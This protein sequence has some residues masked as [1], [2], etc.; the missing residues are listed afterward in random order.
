MDKYKNIKT[1]DNYEKTLKSGMF[2]EFYPELSG[3]WEKDMRIINP[4]MLS[5]V[6]FPQVLE[7]LDTMVVNLNRNN[8]MFKF[9]N[10]RLRN[11]SLHFSELTGEYYVRYKDV[12][13]GW[14]DVYN[15]RSPKR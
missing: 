15:C 11:C 5:A 13:F 3:E 10:V 1:K 14:Y 7:K 8:G 4:P 12:T 9:D 6:V 2:W